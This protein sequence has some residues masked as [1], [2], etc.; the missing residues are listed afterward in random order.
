MR[1]SC[2]LAALAW[3]GGGG[4]VLGLFSVLLVAAVVLL[5]WAVLR[6]RPAKLPARALAARA[7]RR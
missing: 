3:F 7:A 4:Q 1:S 5:W 6:V 2:I